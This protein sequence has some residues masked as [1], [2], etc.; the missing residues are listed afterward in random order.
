VDFGTIGVGQTVT[1]V[2]T[3]RRGG[4][5]DPNAEYCEGVLDEESDDLSFD[6]YAFSGMAPGDT[7]PITARFTPHEVGIHHVLAQVWSWDPSTSHRLSAYVEFRATV[8]AN[9]PP[10]PVCAASTTNIALG[11]YVSGETKDTTFTVT[12]A[13]G[14]T[15][16]G[17]VRFLDANPPPFS[18]V[19]STSY[20]L[21]SGQ[22]QSFTVRY[23]APSVPIGHTVSDARMI[24]L[25]TGCAALGPLTVQATAEPPPQCALSTTVLDFGTVPVGQSADLSFDLHNVGGGT[26]CGTVTEACADF[27]IVVN[28]QYCATPPGFPRVLVRFTPSA[29]G[30]QECKISPGPGCPA[31]LAKGT[32]S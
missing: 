24:G 28:Q 14:G 12:N 32:G 9:G 5:P 7:R 2:L 25:G 16:S 3:L 21:G 31:V 29:A 6:T 20:A 10:L 4:L 15:L 8:V 26:L 22:G 23:T 11:T 19:G 1:H 18:L 30:Y 17:V 27:S 13:G